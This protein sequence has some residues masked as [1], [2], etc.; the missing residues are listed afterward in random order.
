MARSKEYLHASARRIMWTGHCLLK[1]GRMRQGRHAEGRASV[2]ESKHTYEE[3]LEGG[4]QNIDAH[5][6]L[7]SAKQPG[8]RHGERGNHRLARTHI[9]SPRSPGRLLIHGSRLYLVA[10]HQSRMRRE[11]R[12]ERAHTR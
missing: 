10:C 7:V 1:A 6:E 12:H 4:D 8:T 9:H 2:L 3:R 11:G 5:V